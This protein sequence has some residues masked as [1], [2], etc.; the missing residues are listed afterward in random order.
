MCWWRLLEAMPGSRAATSPT[1]GPAWERKCFQ[2]TKITC[3]M[4]SWYDYLII[5]TFYFFITASLLQ[6]TARLLL[7]YCQIT[8]RLLL[9]Y[10]KL[11][12]HTAWSSLITANYFLITANYCLITASLLQITAWLLLN[13]CLITSQL[14]LNCLQITASILLDYCI[15]LLD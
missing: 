8:T 12:H 7:N 10:C 3:K 2:W 15:L 6:I 1:V 9:D 14:L 4:D 5:T 11:L 13:Y